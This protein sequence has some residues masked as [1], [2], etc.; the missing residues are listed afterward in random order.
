MNLAGVLLAISIINRMTENAA[1]RAETAAQLAQD[2]GYVIT[3]N[4]TSLII[5]E[6]E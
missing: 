3:V 5:G 6:A 1:E 2:Y 4:G